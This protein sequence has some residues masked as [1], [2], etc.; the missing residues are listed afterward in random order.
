MNFTDTLNHLIFAWCDRRAIQPLQCL[1]RAYP[2]P[3][4]HPDQKYLV[5]ESL[6]IIKSVCKGE[7]TEAELAQVNAVILTLE[8]TLR[9]VDT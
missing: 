3:L 4:A 9:G 7:I 5:L 6:R 1:L 8:T 2:G